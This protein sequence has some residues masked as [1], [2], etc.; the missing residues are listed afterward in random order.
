MSLL[1][2]ISFLATVLALAF[3]LICL[4]SGLLYVAEIIEE[5]SQAAKRIGQQ[6]THGVILLHIGIYFSDGLPFHLTILG[7]FSHL[8]YLTNF[9]KS[10]P[11]IS[12]NSISF[13]SSCCL[14]ILDHFAWFFYFTDR[15]SSHHPYHSK[16]Y[17]HLDSTALTFLDVTTF[18][19]ICVW[20]VPFYLFL[21]LSANDNVLPSRNGNVFKSNS[22][23]FFIEHFSDLMIFPFYN[24]FRSTYNDF[25]T[26]S[27]P[28][29]NQPS[30]NL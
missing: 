8:I 14:V 22:Q 6:I 28:K 10:W 16:V 25:S 27:N 20:M 7:I 18:F 3:I 12:L 13:L 11:M 30:I 29:S 4:A 2:L 21:S 1:H 26:T 23:V 15:T 19:A 9:S 5:H 17:R 24:R